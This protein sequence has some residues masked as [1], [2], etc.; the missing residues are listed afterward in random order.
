MTKFIIIVALMFFVGFCVSCAKNTSKNN[1]QNPSS[2]LE[3]VTIDRVT[4]SNLP[5]D[6]AAALQQSSKGNVPKYS[7]IETLQ[8]LSSEGTENPDILLALALLQANV[9][10]SGVYI[11]DLR[12][13]LD[14]G[15]AYSEKY[16]DLLTPDIPKKFLI[17][18]DKIDE[19]ERRVQWVED[20]PL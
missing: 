4:F 13:D 18:A 15:R 17:V 16:F 14:L 19:L 11:D 20:N 2:T 8:N 3:T 12:K 1:I 6:L 7:K 5:S 10:D 9:V